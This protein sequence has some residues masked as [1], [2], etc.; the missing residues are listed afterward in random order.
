ML[1]SCHS[2]F[3]YRQL[4]NTPPALLADRL[5]SLRGF[6]KNTTIERML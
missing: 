5:L 3:L 1:P 6:A 4:K 2:G